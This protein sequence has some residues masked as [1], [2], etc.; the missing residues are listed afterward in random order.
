MQRHSEAGGRGSLLAVNVRRNGVKMCP[1]NVTDECRDVRE[2][3]CSANESGG[4]FRSRTRR[5]ENQGYCRFEKRSLA[6]QCFSCEVAERENLDVL[7]PFIDSEQW[8]G[9]PI[10]RRGVSNES[11]SSDDPKAS[12]SSQISQS[13]SRL[14]ATMVV[15]PSRDRGGDAQAVCHGYTAGTGGPKAGFGKARSPQVQTDFA[16]FLKIDHFFGAFLFQ[17]GH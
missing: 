17:T 6:K 3:Y 13:S 9:R 2:Q 8:S 1:V 10:G 7:Q 4:G 14:I 15:R 11:P 12:E 16:I 5:L